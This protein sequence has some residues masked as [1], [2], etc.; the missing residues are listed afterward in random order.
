MPIIRKL[1][2]SGYLH[3]C[4]KSADNGIIF[5]TLEDLL[6]FF[7]LL[8]ISANIHGVIILAI[9]L[10][11]NHFHIGAIF[12]DGES[13]SSFM[14]GVTSVY[15]RLYNRHHGLEGKLFKKPFKSSPKLSEK[16]IKDSLFYI[17]N[18]PVE[19]SAVSTAEEYRWVFLKYLDNDNP[20]SGPF[21]T[22]ELSD[23]ILKL[24][25]KVKA[26]HDAGKYLDYS[27]FDKNFKALKKDER[28]LLIDYIIVTYSVIKRDELLMKFGDY[29]SLILAVNSVAGNE[30]NLTDDVD[31]EDYR[32]Y[33][34]MISIIRDEGLD[35]DTVCFDRKDRGTP[36]D[37]NQLLRLRKRFK[38]E[39]GAS[40]YEIDKFLHLL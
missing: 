10:M 24:M 12:R 21:V 3:I 38:T 28:M 29:K 5:Y 33:G 39:V 15:A 7:T 8:C 20:F 32:H 31:N 2:R 18:N 17:W 16:K 40:D 35:L 23:D 22:S 34:K 9:A 30:Y 1:Y 14:N 25:Q 11:L 36:R 13:A 27:F 37:V 6:V 19:K 26:N 4:Q